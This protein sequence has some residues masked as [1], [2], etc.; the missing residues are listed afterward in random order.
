[1]DE[2]ALNIGIISEKSGKQLFSW[3]LYHTQSNSNIWTV[4]VYLGFITII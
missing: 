2:A 4:W 1:M 3:F